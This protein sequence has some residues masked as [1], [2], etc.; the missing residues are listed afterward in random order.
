MLDSGKRDTRKK[1][2]DEKEFYS[3]PSQ[4]CCRVT[5]ADVAIRWL[6]SCA[7][8]R[9]CRLSFS[10][11]AGVLVCWNFARGN[12]TMAPGSPKNRRCSPDFGLPESSGF[13]YVYAVANV[14]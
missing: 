13:V 14:L 7:V 6:Q 3:P 8:F 1:P 5:V 10:S 11:M 12:C 9:Y 4:L 2:G